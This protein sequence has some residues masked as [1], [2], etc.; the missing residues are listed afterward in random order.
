MIIPFNIQTKKPERTFLLESNKLIASIFFV[1]NQMGTEKVGLITINND[2]N[3]LNE[4]YLI[5]YD[6]STFSYNISEIELTHS[7]FAIVPI[8]N[9][10]RGASYHYDS[11]IESEGTPTE[12]IILIKNNGLYFLD[13]KKIP[14]K[15]NSQDFLAQ[16]KAFVDRIRLEGK[17]LTYCETHEDLLMLSMD[18]NVLYTLKFS[19]QGKNV[20]VIQRTNNFLSPLLR[21][22]KLPQVPHHTRYTSYRSHNGLLWR[23]THFYFNESYVVMLMPTV[24]FSG[25]NILI[26]VAS[27]LEFLNKENTE[28]MNNLLQNACFEV[29]ETDGSKG[30]KSD[31]ELKI[32]FECFTK[33]EDNKMHVQLED[34]NFFL[35]LQSSFNFSPIIIS[36]QEESKRKPYIIDLGIYRT[37]EDDDKAGGKKSDKNKNL[38]KNPHMILVPNANHDSQ[39][40]SKEDS[41]SRHELRKLVQGKE[42]KSKDIDKNKQRKKEIRNIITQANKVSKLTDFAHLDNSTNKKEWVLREISKRKNKK[43]ESNRKNI[44]YE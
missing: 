23:T 39:E 13:L 22:S 21:M 38:K 31:I 41:L 7:L 27:L 32:D 25:N 43:K 30:E 29:K 1:N 28:T 16:N 8:H 10:Y 20:S 44:G 11:I 42:E 5:E 12:Y 2:M 15:K 35:D 6:I 33:F 34:I 36:P 9:D 19:S 18:F 37:L 26:R 4:N 40:E 3:S 17:S 14:L 24:S